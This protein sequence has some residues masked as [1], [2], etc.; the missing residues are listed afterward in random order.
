MAFSNGLYFLSL[1]F[2]SYYS[3]DAPASEVL[4]EITVFMFTIGYTEQRRIQNSVK[5]FC[6][7]C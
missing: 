3:K 6:E 7:N 5:V 1:V 4:E 2:N